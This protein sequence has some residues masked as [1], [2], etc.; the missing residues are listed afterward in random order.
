MGVIEVPTYLDRTET[1]K[2]M[3]SWV[4]AH[5]G[6]NKAN[7]PAILTEGS[8][9][10]PITIN[11]TDAQLIEALQFSDSQI[12]GRIFRVPPHMIGILERTSGLRG[13]EQLERSFFANTLVGYLQIGMEAL[14]GCHRKGRYVHFDTTARVRGATLERAQAGALLMNSGV[15]VADEIRDWFDWDVLPN[16][17]G[18][19]SFMPINTQLLDAARMLKAMAAIEK[20]VNSPSGTPGGT[21]SG[22]QP[23]PGQ[24][25][26]KSGLPPRKGSPNGA[27]QVVGRGDDM[28]VEE[29]IEIVETAL[30]QAYR[31]QYAADVAVNGNG[32]KEY[33]DE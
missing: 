14:S 18:Q 32:H 31:M 19:E 33:E 20:D 1:R 29:A 26:A 2:M 6:L 30:N 3:R 13:I 24:A 25:P 8:T 9:F 21:V 7:L 27:A 28:T 11:P 23:R 15:S 22:S 4:A 12:C 5:Q 16:G 17:R 10:K